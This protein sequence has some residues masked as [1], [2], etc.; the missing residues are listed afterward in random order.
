MLRTRRQLTINDLSAATDLT[1]TELSQVERTGVT[2]SVNLAKI[3]VAL[4][5]PLLCLFIDREQI[6]FLFDASIEEI[7]LRE[8]EHTDKMLRAFLDKVFNALGDGD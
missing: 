6:D 7:Q 5:I 8:R 2:T 3:A 4:D 1:A